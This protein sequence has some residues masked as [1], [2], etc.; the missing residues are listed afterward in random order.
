MT[1]VTGLFMSNGTK[2]ERNQ[3][4]TWRVRPVERSLLPRPLLQR[5]FHRPA[6][7]TFQRCLAV[8]IH[9]AGPGRQGGLS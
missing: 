2:P 1:K 7:T 6:P 9:F 8:H 3:S 4:E 5:I